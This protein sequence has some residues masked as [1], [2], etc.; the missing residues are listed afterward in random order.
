MV[1]RMACGIYG[2]AFWKMLLSLSEFGYG[3]NFEGSC[4]KQR[5]HAQML[6]NV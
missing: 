3:W 1:F 4:P 6:L 2:M 5:G